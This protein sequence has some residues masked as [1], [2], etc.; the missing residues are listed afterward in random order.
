MLVLKG[1]SFGVGA[2]V[3]HAAEELEG[4]LID[5]ATR[6]IRLTQVLPKDEAGRH[7]ARQLLRSGTS[8]AAN[9]AEARSAESRADFIHKLRIVVKEL[10]E[11][12][13]WLKI[14]ARTDM[15]PGDRLVAITDET[16]QMCRMIGASL[17]TA[18][19]GQVAARTND[20]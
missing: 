12:Q 6:I 15:L 20:K 2:T 1:Q 3:M 13:V 19:R 11:T 14:L 4:R 9:Y 8:P 16:G 7:V 18:K 5:L 10:G 17:A